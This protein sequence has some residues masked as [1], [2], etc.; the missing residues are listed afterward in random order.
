MLEWNSFLYLLL[1]QGMAMLDKFLTHLERKIKYSLYSQSQL[2]SKI[3][4]NKK[5]SFY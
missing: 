4:L 3:H 5:S 2:Q 1:L